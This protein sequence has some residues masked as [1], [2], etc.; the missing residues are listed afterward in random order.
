MSPAKLVQVP[1]QLNVM[2]AT[3]TPPFSLIIHAF[4]M[5]PITQSQHLLAQP[6]LALFAQVVSPDAKSAL[7][8]L[9]PTVKVV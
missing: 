1:A 9:I 8:P 7:A 3:P 5:T 4:A 2:D 6:A